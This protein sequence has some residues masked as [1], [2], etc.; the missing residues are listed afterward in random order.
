MAK[1]K[2]I[3]GERITLKMS[4]EGETRGMSIKQTMKKWGAAGMSRSEI[5]DKLEVEL[6]PG[7]RIFEGIV[8]NFQNAAGEVVDYVAIE[9]VHA[10]W[11]GADEWIWVSVS[12]ES[13]CEDCAERD[14][15]VKTWE[16]W[17]ALGLPGMGTTVCGWRCRCSLEPADFAGD[18]TDVTE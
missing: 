8:S 13:R 18:F 17:E 16:E 7:G 2:N 12:D 10:E 1:K 14:L 9:Q 6:S 4:V 3:I 5:I 15:E 11:Q